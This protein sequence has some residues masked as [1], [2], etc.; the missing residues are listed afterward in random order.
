MVASQ[1]KEIIFI[2]D[3]VCKQEADRLK[4]LLPSVHIAPKEEVLCIRW[5]TSILKDSQQVCI[6]T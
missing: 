2:L 5:E 3:L 6:L 4:R 1:Q